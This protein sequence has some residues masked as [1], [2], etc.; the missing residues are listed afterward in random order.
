MIA[1]DHVL[2]SLQAHWGPARVQEIQ[3]DSQHF[4]EVELLFDSS[5]GSNPHVFCSTERGY[6]DVVP[7]LSKVGDIVCLI[8][9]LQVPYVLRK[10]GEKFRL[11][12]DSYIHG[13]MNGEGLQLTYAVKDFE[14]V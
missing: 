5:N 9:G 6:I 14:L 1:S 4:Q 12:G 10:F 8:H 13:I 7:Q 2:E 3:Q 11:V